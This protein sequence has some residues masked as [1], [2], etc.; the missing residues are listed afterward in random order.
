MKL[1]RDVQR[2]ILEAL[3]TIYPDQCFDVLNSISVD[4]EIGLANLFYL[5]EHQLVEAKFVNTAGHIS[6]LAGRQ[7]L[8]AKGSDFLK[9]DGGVTAILGVVTVKFH[10]DALKQLIELRLSEAHI[11]K[12]E[13]NRLLQSVRE[14]PAES[15]KH[16]TTKLLDLG[17]D[18]LPRAVEL[19]RTVLT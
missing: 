19:I 8:T 14:L 3:Q 17:M 6:D 2:S 16:L 13:K 1:D 7:R 11:P 4:R 5:T 9:D 15:I 18:N 10:E 12:E